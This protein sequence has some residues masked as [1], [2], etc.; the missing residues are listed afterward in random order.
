MHLFVENGDLLAW[1]DAGIPSNQGVPEERVSVRHFVEQVAG[2]VHGRGESVGEEDEFGG[3]IKARA[4]AE[5][6]G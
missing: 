6:M 3:E 4:G 5:A 1:A 2:I